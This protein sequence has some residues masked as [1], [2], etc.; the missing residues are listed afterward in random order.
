VTNTGNLRMEAVAPYGTS[1]ARTATSSSALELNHW[2][3][4]AGTYDGNDVAVYI[5]GSLMGSTHYTS[6]VGLSSDVSIP[7]GLGHLQNWSLQWF[8]GM[9]DDPAVYASALSAAEIGA[10]SSVPESETIAL[11]LGAL[12]GLFTLARRRWRQASLR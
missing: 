8:Y 3:F 2:Y 1:G 12:A 11:G 9:I 10:L 4:V 6:T 7:V 5:D